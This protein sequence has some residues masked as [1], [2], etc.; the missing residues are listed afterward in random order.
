MIVLFRSRTGKIQCARTCVIME[1]KSTA[2][3]THCALKGKKVARFSDL[4]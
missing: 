3:L 1:K 4:N 2:R